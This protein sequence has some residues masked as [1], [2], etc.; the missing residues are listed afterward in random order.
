V[1]ERVV[2]ED[3]L[4]AA[5]DLDRELGLG[6]DV[7]RLRREDDLVSRADQGVLELAEDERLGRRFVA[8]LGR[9]LRVIS[10]DANDLHAPILTD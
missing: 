2:V 10:A 5:A 6:V 7:G 4:A 9:V 8:E 3:P 1:V